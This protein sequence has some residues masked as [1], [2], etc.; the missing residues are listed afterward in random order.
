M[1]FN[2]F[3][4]KPKVFTGLYIT[5]ASAAFVVVI[6]LI[7]WLE[8][9]RF[10]SVF[11]PTESENQNQ[12]QVPLTDTI[13]SHFLLLMIILAGFAIGYGV[14]AYRIR[15]SHGN[16]N[17]GQK[18]TARWT[19]RQELDEQFIKIDEKET[20]FPGMGGIPIA[21]DG[22]KL[23]IDNTN[24]NNLI[25]GGTRS[26][27]GQ[28]T[29]EPM[30]EIISR[31]E[32]KC[33][34]VITDPKMELANKM[35][36]VL[37]R[38][39]YE[40]HILNLIDPE[41][42]MGYNPLALIVQEYKDG[43]EDTAQQLAA[44]L[45]YNV[46]ANNE[47]DKDRYFTDQAR[48]VFVA[49]VMADIKDNIELDREQ[50]KRW[51]HEHD[52]KEIMR[53]REYY[54]KLYGD[55]YIFYRL[56]EA[57]DKIISNEGDISDI[58]ILVELQYQNSAGVLDGDLMQVISELTEDLIKE[59][60]Q[61]KYKEST[62]QKKRFYPSTENEK[63]INIYSIIKMCNY[64]VS[65][66]RG[67]NRTALDEYFDNRPE[68]DFSRIMYGSVITA[69]ENTKGTIM[70]VFRGGVSIFGYDSIAKMTSESTMD[71]MDVGFGEKPVAVF[72]A[73]PDY[74][75]S[76]W[77][78][79]T[80]FINQ[81]YFILAKLATSMPGGK[82]LRRVMFILDEFGNLPALD[83]FENIITVC[84]GRNMTF[85]LAVQSLA[86]VNVKYRESADTIT[87]NCGNWIYIMTGDN[88]TAD[89]ISKKL[90][91]E[92]ITTVNRTGKKLSIS[93]ELTEMS[94]E[95]PLLTAAELMLL[96]MGETV[97]LRPMYRE[98]KGTKEKIAVKAHPI[99]NMG[100][101]RM[102]YAYQFLG[103]VFPQDQLLYQSDR[104]AQ[105]RS[106]VTYLKDMKIKIVSGYVETTSHIDLQERSR[107]GEKYMK[108]LQFKNAPF[109]PIVSAAPDGQVAEREEADY[110]RL[111]SALSLLNLS[112]QEMI[113]YLEAGK[114]YEDDEGIVQV[115]NPEYVLINS[116][117]IEY[118]HT[119]WGCNSRRIQEKGFDL[120]DLVLPLS[121][122]P[123]TEEELYLKDLI[124]QEILNAGR[125]EVL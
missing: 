85:T 11:A 37:R 21:R 96:E 107:S 53:E 60:R 47:G 61:F 108:F 97:V 119:L 71:F 57:I 20:S 99:A 31:A 48:N 50:N 39:G 92:T 27:K 8:N 105:M 67:Q 103:D 30:A 63:K 114:C 14:F 22:D 17:V 29:I 93:K 43:N 6:F 58:G 9:F 73:L 40:T 90:G 34:M 19:T 104:L 26:G 54:K 95:K 68:D 125:R 59:T 4:S 36:P 117:L 66:P 122:K 18:G 100:E 121:E 115:Q 41:Y 1:K 111:K 80:V 72:I 87:G 35:I 75:S 77:F 52:K 69:S 49:A 76:N 106:K 45:G 81:M 3:L 65:Q 25:I 124:E 55:D 70:S 123:V 112:P 16:L 89:E 88:D 98:A 94:D 82:L 56:K 42:S 78:I 2:R 110:I 46:F 102:K 33:S 120:L 15:V 38:R 83:N 116:S 101:Y 74:D 28:T 79:A 109:V 23:Y 62:F 84:L 10:E 86:Q 113:L 12:L 13:T 5:A 32:N 64:L 118:A 24:V 7:N 44:S 91:P 51:N